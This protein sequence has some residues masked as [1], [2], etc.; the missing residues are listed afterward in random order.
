MP[1]NK[2]CS[3]EAFKANMHQLIKE[4]GY[5]NPQAF[6]IAM[7]VLGRACGVEGQ[8]GSPEE[9][10]AAKKESKAEVDRFDRL[11]GAILESR[12]TTAKDL[13]TSME[14]LAK[15]EKKTASLGWDQQTIDLVANI[16]WAVKKNDRAKGQKLLDL[17]VRSGVQV[18]QG[19][20]NEVQQWLEGMIEQR[21]IDGAVN[22]DEF[23]VIPPFSP[24][25]EIIPRK[26]LEGFVLAGTPESHRFMTAEG[27][28]GIVYFDPRGRAVAAGLSE[29]DTGVLFDLAKTMGFKPKFGPTEQ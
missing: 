6:A 1:L 9:I 29:M 3:V 13:A 4:D 28:V 27:L 22:R 19:L 8:L 12:P 5:K 14:E 15:T 10:V 21:E 17:L 2:S 20:V 18:S 7:S 11:F 23:D 24:E 26:T 16:A 25:W